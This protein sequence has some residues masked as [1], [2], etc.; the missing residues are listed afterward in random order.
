MIKIA[1]CIKV[2]ALT[3]HVPGKLHHAH[4]SGIVVFPD[5]ELLAVYFHAIT[6]AHHDQKIYGTRRMPGEDKWSKPFVI[7]NFKLGMAGNPVVWIAP[8]TG[9]LW[10]FYVISIGGW[11]VC[12]PR[13]TY[14]DD[15]GKTWSKSKAL[16][17]FISRGT[18]N[19]P[20]L[21]EKEPGKGWYVL[22]A[23][24]EFRDYFGVF[25]VSEDQGKKWT[26]YGRVKIPDDEIPEGKKWGRLVEQPTV[27]EREDGSLWALMRTERPIGKMYQTE[28]FDGGLTWS[29]AKP[30]FL[31]NPG[32]GFLMRR[33]QSGNLGI[34]YNHAPVPPDHGLE[35]NPLSVAISE[36][37]GKTWKYR[38]NIMEAQGDQ[39]HQRIG[40]YPTMMQ[41]ADGTIHATWS[42]S[43]P[44]MIDGVEKNI[45]DINY[46]SFTEKWVKEHEF[47]EEPFEL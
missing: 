15:R 27:V 23:Y 17:W 43:H 31:P 29:P 10:L 35:R 25:Y 2:E 13:C 44:E 40:Q 11:S 28:S 14:S 24:I 4:C 22:P 19:P 5:G 30:Y 8:D 20:V 47:F 41:G 3:Q 36:D 12:N 6:E 26:E 39:V 9:R 21:K 16:Y 33:L 34:I 1:D 38:R 37:E 18:K 42:F 46:T 7:R 32:G 45:T